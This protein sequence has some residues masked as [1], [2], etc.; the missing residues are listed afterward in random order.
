LLN[1]NIEDFDG[2]FKVGL[3]IS[4][5][6]RATLLPRPERVIENFYLDELGHARSNLEDL[7]RL[8][9]DYSTLLFPA[10]LVPVASATHSAHAATLVFPLL[11]APFHLF[12][13]LF[14]VLVLPVFPLTEL[15][16]ELLHHVTT[17]TTSTSTSTTTTAATSETSSSSERMWTRVL[18]AFRTAHESFHHLIHKIFWTVFSFL[19]HGC[20][21]R[22]HGDHDIRG[23]TRLFDG[24]HGVLVRQALLTSGAVIEIFTHGALVADSND[25]GHTA[26]ITSNI[27][28]NGLT[29]FFRL[30]GRREIVRFE[31]GVEGFFGLLL[32]LRVDEI[33]QSFSW[34]SF[35]VTF[36]AFLL[37]LNRLNFIFH[38]LVLDL[39]RLDLADA[40]RLDVKGELHVGTSSDS[41]GKL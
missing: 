8:A 19:F 2:D 34:N 37:A 18:L 22:Q 28:V 1:G 24:K 13:P 31:K 15:S 35:A 33:L 38:F 41:E 6:D 32:K 21:F 9:L 23:T 36:L 5:G 7:F 40:N 20:V 3:F 11:L 27:L 25:R 16:H 12:L 10:L 17:L 29:V 30:I 4:K 26:T 14:R 39:S